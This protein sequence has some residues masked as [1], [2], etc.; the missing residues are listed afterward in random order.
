MDL[1]FSIDNVVAAIAYVKNYPMPSKLVLVCTGVFL[2][3]LAMR[4]AAQGFV[5]LM[6]RYHFLETCAFIVIAVLGVK[7]VL[8][9]PRHFLPPGNLIHDF[10]ASKYFDLG[11]SVLTLLIFI[12]PVVIHRLKGQPTEA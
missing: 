4:F 6:Q 1:A 12:V 5:K 7:L 3:I 2:G 10:L 8:S 9:I 11:T